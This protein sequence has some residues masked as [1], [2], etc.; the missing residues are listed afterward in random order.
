M[1]YGR[2]RLSFVV[3]MV[4]FL[5]AG[6]ADRHV[7]ISGVCRFSPASAAERGGSLVARVGARCAD[8]GCR[9]R[10]RDY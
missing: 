5:A 8:G 3:E 2:R 6:D 4:R 10:I 1:D 7:R 9:Y